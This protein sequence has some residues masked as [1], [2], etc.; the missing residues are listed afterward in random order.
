MED[1]STDLVPQSSFSII[2]FI[3]D[4]FRIVSK[5]EVPS[6][7]SLLSNL[8]KATVVIGISSVIFAIIDSIVAPIAKF[9]LNG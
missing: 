8:G 9:L 5:L 2:S 1:K 7:V 4:V 6:F 3:A